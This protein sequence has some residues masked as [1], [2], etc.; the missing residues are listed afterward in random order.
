MFNDFTF[1]RRILIVLLKG[2]WWYSER[3]DVRFAY[4]FGQSADG[5]WFLDRWFRSKRLNSALMLF[6]PKNVTQYWLLLNEILCNFDKILDH[7]E[8]VSSAPPTQISRRTTNY[9]QIKAYH[10]QHVGSRWCHLRPKEIVKHHE[11]SLNFSVS[12]W[13][14]AK[15]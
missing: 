8:T 9:H 12:R 14:E 6:S 11:S 15:L 13:D 3:S 2:Q 10:R 7:R 4:D 5:N 1:S